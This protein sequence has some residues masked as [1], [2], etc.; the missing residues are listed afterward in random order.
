V[1]DDRKDFEEAFNID[2]SRVKWDG[3]AYVFAYKPTERNPRINSLYDGWRKGVD[4]ANAQ[5]MAQSQAPARTWE[6][7]KACFGSGGKRVG[8]GAQ[9]RGNCIFCGGTGRV[10]KGSQ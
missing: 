4:W 10:P 8:Y 1:I 9:G 5:R 2:L 3:S 6:G 7:C